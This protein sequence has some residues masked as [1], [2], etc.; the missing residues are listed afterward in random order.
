MICWPNL[1]SCVV[2]FC[3]FS[4]WESLFVQTV[5]MVSVLVPDSYSQSSCTIV[6]SQEGLCRWVLLADT[7]CWA[8][9]QR[10]DYFLSL[11]AGGFKGIT[12][13]TCEDI[14]WLYKHDFTEKLIISDVQRVKN[15]QYNQVLQQRKWKLSATDVVSTKDFINT[16]NNNVE[17]N[18]QRC[19][20]HLHMPYG[21]F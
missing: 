1:T 8:W 18:F 10:N 7:L 20:R 16:K 4:G 12:T 11:P 21:L 9:I 19:H 13:L 2:C 6:N 15:V 14:E 3:M 5:V 17:C